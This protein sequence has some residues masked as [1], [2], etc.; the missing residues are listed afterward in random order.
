MFLYR[1]AA[2]FLMSVRTTVC[3]LKKNVQHSLLTDMKALGLHLDDVQVRNKRRK[4]IKTCFFV[5]FD[6]YYIPFIT[7]NILALFECS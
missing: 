5:N 3:I 2:Q 7:L 4:K 6:A 1:N